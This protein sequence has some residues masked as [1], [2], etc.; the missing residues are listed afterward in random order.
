MLTEFIEKLNPAAST[1]S[2]NNARRCLR[3]LGSKLPKRYP[4]V[5]CTV[6]CNLLPNR[7]DEPP[8]LKKTTATG[9][10]VRPKALVKPRCATKYNS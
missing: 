3:N 1:I 10:T 7:Q 9:A 8:D 5:E 6:A 2:N 4:A